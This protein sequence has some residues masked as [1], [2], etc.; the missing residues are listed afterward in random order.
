MRWAAPS[1]TS[2]TASYNNFVTGRFLEA[3]DVLSSRGATVVLATTPYYDSGQQPTGSIWPEDTPTRVVIDNFI[4]NLVVAKDKTT[5]G[6]PNVALMNVGSWVS[7]DGHYAKVVD[8]V[9]TR[10]TDGVHFTIAGGRA[11]APKILPVLASLG[12]SHHD[13][14]PGGAW[15]GTLPKAEPAWYEKLPCN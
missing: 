3:A 5:P 14:S 15:D 9:T 4:I 8:G 6:T 13:H 2:V 7:P 10:C 11:L 1:R 12:Q